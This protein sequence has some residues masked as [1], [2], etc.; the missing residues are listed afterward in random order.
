MLQSIKKRLKDQRGLTL[1]EL[2]AVI[3]ILGIIA[4]IAIPSINS[5]MDKS[6]EDAI[7][8]DAKLILNA[9]KLYEANG[10]EIP[11]A[12]VTSADLETDYLEGVSTFTG[13]DAVAYTV[14][15]ESGGLAISGTGVKGKMKVV[16]D[17]TLLSGIDGL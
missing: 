9:A 8:A 13:T 6:R 14:T 7:K 3:V 15:K 2:L 10:N 5:V 1:I 17:K 12:G 16:F 4:A 11:T